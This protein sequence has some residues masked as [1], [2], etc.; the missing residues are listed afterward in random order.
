MTESCS[1]AVGGEWRW[2][3]ISLSGSFIVGK[4]DRFVPKPKNKVIMVGR[5]KGI[6]NGILALK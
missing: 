2:M 1:G 6:I 5:C 3:C 4:E